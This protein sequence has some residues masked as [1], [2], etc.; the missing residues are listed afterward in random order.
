MGNRKNVEFVSS[1]STLTSDR[2]NLK[3]IMGDSTDKKRKAR[4]M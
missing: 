2:R 1:I 4:S 3:M